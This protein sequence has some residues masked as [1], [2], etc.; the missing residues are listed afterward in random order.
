MA[1]NDTDSQF[2]VAVIVSAILILLLH[3]LASFFPSARS[4][5]IHHLLFFSLPVRLALVSAGILVCIPEINKKVVSL[6]RLAFLW[7]V[8]RL[9]RAKKLV[10]FLTLSVISFVPFWLLRTRTHFLGDGYL[11]I[12]SLAGGL[13]LKLTALLDILLHA[14]LY[15]ILKGTGEV[16]A[17]TFSTLFSSIGGIIFVFVLLLLSDC[18]G[19]ERLKAAIV[20]FLMASMGMVQ[21]FFGYVESYTLLSIGIT[22]YL[23]FSCYHLQKRCSIAFPSLALSLTVC[24]HISAAALVPSLMYLCFTSTKGAHWR[25]KL[26]NL[27]KAGGAFVIPILLLA[28]LV[29][30][31][32]RS[33]ER[34]LRGAEGSVFLSLL[35]S[36][37]D[38]P[39]SLFSL[40]HL[41]DIFN[42]L[43][44]IS[45]VGLMACLLLVVY[46]RKIDFKQPLIRF[47]LLASGFSLLF[48]FALNP[49][50][51]ASRDW[52][53]LSLPSI[54]YTLLGAYLVIRCVKNRGRLRSVGLILTTVAFVHTVPWILVNADADKAIKRFKLLIQTKSVRSPWY[55]HEELGIYYR[56]LGMVDQAIEEYRGSVNASPSNARLRLS[57]G[58]LYWEKELYD[59]AIQEYEQ[60]IAI[61][62]NLAFAYYNLACVYVY[63]E[64]YD[65]AIYEYEQAI[66]INPRLAM[67]YYHLGMV[68]QKKNLYDQAIRALTEY[69]SMKPDDANAHFEL[70]CI[71]EKQNRWSQATSEWKKALTL[72]P[73]LQK[74]RLKLH[75]VPI[76]QD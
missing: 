50:I 8:R 24:A 12:R 48:T 14:E 28:G 54:P 49:K 35:S 73:Y 20:F 31:S 11:Y 66:A 65:Q 16:D 27:A 2:Q 53:L 76:D 23:L 60:A 25:R 68:Y 38:P 34:L 74:A 7:I 61:N 55:A 63:K 22:I 64:M 47:L 42:E 30:H 39:Y 45:P 51:G 17:L 41:V 56:E 44:L 59:Q 58:A 4:W 6:L 62:P 15:K 46:R 29:I 10:V 19:K 43:L 36:V 1:E 9:P 13:Q 3:L 52:D 33:M 72:N 67:A 75:G 5:G 40:A 70:G 21:L 69:L 71:Y 26:T 32:G 37:E 57:L 18:L